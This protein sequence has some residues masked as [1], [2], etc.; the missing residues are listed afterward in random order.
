MKS[1]Y[2]FLFLLFLCAACKSGD[3]K[4]D[5]PA[6]NDVDAARNFIRAA[7]D[8]KYQVAA[9]YMLDDTQNANYL[10]NVAERGYQRA[11]QSIKDGYRAASINIVKVMR[12]VKDSVTVVIYSNSFYRDNHD[13]LK[14]L[15]VN[16]K[17]LIDFKYLFEHGNDTLYMKDIINDKIK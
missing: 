15:N 14:V 8:G 3:K 6:E 2:P 10:F 1:F 16:G 11:D 7:L 5:T 13:T 12:P 9:N 4:A 17:W